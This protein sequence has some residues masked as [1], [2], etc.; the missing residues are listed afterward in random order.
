MQELTRRLRRKFWAVRVIT[1]EE[2]GSVRDQSQQQQLESNQ[3]AATKF[4]ALLD[5]ATGHAAEPTSNTAWRLLLE[6]TVSL[7]YLCAFGSIFD[8]QKQQ[9]G[10]A[11]VRLPQ[12]GTVRVD[13]ECDYY[14]VARR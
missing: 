8:Q 10:A 14:T 7:D 12:C 3:S 5:F 9:A 11:D 4:R 2:E 1:D 13:I 6:T